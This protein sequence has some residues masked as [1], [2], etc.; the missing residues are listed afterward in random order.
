M[1][2]EAISILLVEDSVADARRIETMLRY[3]EHAEC[4]FMHALSLAE[5]LEQLVLKKPD[6]ALVDL[7]LPDSTGT[8][9]VT[10]LTS[11]YI[12]LP[13][14]VLTGHDDWQS[15]ITA[16]QMGAQD[17]LGKNDL[18]SETLE[19]IIFHAM[20]RKRVSRKQAKFYRDSV[21]AIVP[22]ASL[23]ELEHKFQKLSN[24]LQD[25]QSRIRARMPSLATEI[26][27]IIN[28][29][30]VRAD[31]STRTVSDEAKAVT[32]RYSDIDMFESTTDPRSI[33]TDVLAKYSHGS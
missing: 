24:T 10:E 22:N 2:K 12:D 3:T 23:V 19:K 7:G 25:V 5:A 16:I 18:R 1:T 33:L 29:N 32:A 11:R 20:E 4:S 17:Y 31:T 21:R 27:S 13:V 15:G 6:V 30:I 26:D 9:V 8:L 14:I 28:Q